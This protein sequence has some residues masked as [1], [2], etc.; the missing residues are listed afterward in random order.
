MGFLKRFFVILGLLSLNVPFVNGGY[1]GIYN[2]TGESFVIGKVRISGLYL[3]KVRLGDLYEPHIEKDM[4]NS[5]HLGEIVPAKGF[6]VIHYTYNCKYEVETI[7]VE[8]LPQGRRERYNIDLFFHEEK[9][10]YKG[11]YKIACKFAGM[12][13]YSII[14][15]PHLAHLCDRLIIISK[16]TFKEHFSDCGIF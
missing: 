6:F 9:V 15:D 3:Q 5:G 1:I 16:Q 2:T 11:G 10:T 12:S 13:D 14:P 8:L 7:L 4:D